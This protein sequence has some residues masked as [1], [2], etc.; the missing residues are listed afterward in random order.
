MT[1][2]ILG[3]A[4]HV[5]VN[6]LVSRLKDRSTDLFETYQGGRM[7]PRLGCFRN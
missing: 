7:P 5:S 1:Q 2:I 4:V 3:W 6:F